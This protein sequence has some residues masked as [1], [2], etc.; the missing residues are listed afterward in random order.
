M[1]GNEN[2][3]EMAVDRRGGHPFSRDMAP[4]AVRPDPSIIPP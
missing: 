4:A 1:G 2:G 3:V